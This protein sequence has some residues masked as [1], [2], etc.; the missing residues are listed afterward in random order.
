M[1][2]ILYTLTLTHI[3]ILSV[4]LYLHRS[5]SHKSVVFHPFLNHFFRFWLWLTTGMITK[6]WVAIHR[7]HHAFCETEDDPHSPKFNGLLNIVFKGAF[8]YREEAK[9]EETIEKY[10][11][12]TPD[13]FLEKNLYSKYP[14]GGI[15]IMLMINI[16]LFGFLIGFLI[17]FVQILWIVVNF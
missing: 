11:K 3:T 8:Y 16:S 7:K 15:L 4:T 2:Y 5:Q 10:G 6:E 13:D 12:G 17:W 9:N 14:Y 1:F